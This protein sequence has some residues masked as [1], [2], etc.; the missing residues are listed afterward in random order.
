MKIEDFTSK[1]SFTRVVFKFD[2]TVNGKEV[3][4]T[5]EREESEWSMDDD[6]VIENDD[7]LTE[8]EYEAVCD[9][10]YEKFSRKIVNNF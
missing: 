5:Y 10:V 1:H 2:L 3:N 7:D 9:Y 8:D 4:G 6:I